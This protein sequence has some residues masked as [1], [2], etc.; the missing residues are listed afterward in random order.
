MSSH[1]V[2]LRS[3]SPITSTAPANK[4]VGI[5]QSITY[6]SS[7][8]PILSLT[9]G[10]ID[11]ATTLIYLATGLYPFFLIYADEVLIDA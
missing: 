6:G 2:D 11:T 1:N 8:T 3:D 10:M 4:Y 5:D 9:A 7:D